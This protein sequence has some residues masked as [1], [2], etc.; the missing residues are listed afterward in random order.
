M[1]RVSCLAAGVNIGSAPLRAAELTAAVDCA[2]DAR[3]LD[4][5]FGRYP[6]QWAQWISKDGN[7][8]RF[9]LPAATRT[10]PQTGLYS[11][12]SVAGDLEMAA[13]YEILSM[14]KPEGGYGVTCG[15]V[16][17]AA[18][19]GSVA[20]ARGENAGKG[21]CYVATLGKMVDNEPKYESTYYPSTAKSGRLVLRRE[22]KEVICLAADSPQGEPQELVRLPFGPGTV[23]KVRI[24]ADLG[25]SHTSLDA[26]INQIQIRAVEIA[27]GIPKHEPPREWSWWWWAGLGSMGVVAVGLGAFRFRAGRWPFTGGDD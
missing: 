11:Y 3:K 20:L 1:S 27:G 2:A 13:N 6:A 26:R 5:L 9:Y 19:G 8:V 12:F 10:I 22:N 17:D 7:G 16:L 24:I 4:S 21:S 23:Q 14:P 25:G 18:D 15:I